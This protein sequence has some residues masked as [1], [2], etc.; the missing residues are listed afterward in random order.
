MSI[1]LVPLCALTVLCL[2]SLDARRRRRHGGRGRRP[3]RYVVR[4]TGRGAKRCAAPMAAGGV[5]CALCPTCMVMRM[6]SAQKRA[7]DAAAA[8]TLAYL[9]VKLAVYTRCAIS[10]PVRDGCSRAEGV[11]VAAQPLRPLTPAR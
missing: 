10:G 9:A 5:G 8:L 2:Y 7:D 3:A 11:P 6:T 1:A 4:S